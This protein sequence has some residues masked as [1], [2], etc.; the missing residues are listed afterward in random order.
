M[1]SSLV[2]HI[3]FLAEGETMTP[4]PLP[5]RG[6]LKVVLSNLLEIMNVELQSEM[7]G[8]LHALGPSTHASSS[9][10]K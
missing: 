5:N 8:K 10:F 6:W 2:L 9:R 3:R 4:W 1:A 7:I